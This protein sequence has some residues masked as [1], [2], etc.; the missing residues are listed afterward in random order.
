MMEKSSIARIVLTT[1]ATLDDARAL[2]RLLVEEHLA[3]CATIIPSVESIYQ[4]KGEIEESKEALLLLKTVENKLEELEARL[5]S[6]HKYQTPE[7][8]VLDVDGG[9]SEYLRWLA[10]S[11]QA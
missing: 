10:D 11:L 5:F 4:W 7:F 6:L 3:A 1:T 9:G 8:L 2:G